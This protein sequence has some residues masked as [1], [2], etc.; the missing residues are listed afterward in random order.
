MDCRWRRVWLAHV[1]DLAEFS[2]SFVTRPSPNES[3]GELKMKYEEAGRGP[4][5]T[6]DA[7]VSAK[8]TGATATHNTV[9]LEYQP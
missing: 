8:E 9:C 3:P 4:I 2:D 1:I 7:S 5:T 6:V